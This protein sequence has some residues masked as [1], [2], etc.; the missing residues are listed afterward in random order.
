MEVG[1][2]QALIQF[3]EGIIRFCGT[4]IDG[5][6]QGS[7]FRKKKRA[8]QGWFPESWRR[9]CWRR[10]H[11]AS[12]GWRVGSRMVSSTPAAESAASG[13]EE[14][15]G[16]WCCRDRQ[17]VFV[18]VFFL[19]VSG[20]VVV[21][22]L[23]IACGMSMAMIM[24]LAVIVFMLVSVAVAV[25]VLMLVRMFMNEAVML[26]WVLMLMMVAVFMLVFVRMFSV[27]IFLHVL[28]LVECAE[29][30]PF[31]HP[32]LY[33][34]YASFSSSG[35]T[36]LFHFSAILSFR[37]E[38]MGFRY[39]KPRLSSSGAGVSM[40]TARSC[41]CLPGKSTFGPVLMIVIKKAETMQIVQGVQGI[42]GQ[43]QCR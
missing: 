24:P 33:S 5:D 25:V 14:R 11:H 3:P 28:S 9:N 40:L 21:V 18:V 34:L 12:S 27:H 41:R 17:S 16:L 22:G 1:L 43:K 36:T 6:D 35:R 13:V 15:S 10:L 26:M 23:Q 2:V 39:G 7:I 19:V 32:G 8:G 29:C 31:R 37:S 20:V 30:R 38:V 4:S 42:R